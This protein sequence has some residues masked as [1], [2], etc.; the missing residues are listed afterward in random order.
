M[1][2]KRMMIQTSGN[3]QIPLDLYIPEVTDEID[4]HIQRPSV[5]ICPGG[6]YCF[7]SKRESEPVALAFAAAGFNAFVVWNRV[8]PHCFPLPQQDAA[9]AMAFVRAHAQEWH[10]DPNR[11]AILGFSAGGHLAGSI[12]TLW[13]KAELWQDIG[14]LPEQVRPNAMVLC[15]PV[16]TGGKYAHR[17]S[18]ESLSGTTDEREHEKYSVNG[19]VT[20][21]CPPT[22][23]WHTFD[24]DA[25][26]V[27]NSLLMA[28]ALADHGILTELHIYAHG[29]HGASLCNEQTA[30]VK[31]PTLVLPDNAGWVDAAQRF[32]LSTMGA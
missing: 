23:L 3:T 15:Y 2:G 21:Y 25:V 32:L 14:L 6:G 10:T 7:L 13:H 4:E 27:Q 16:I 29:G 19:W 1:I 5:V 17:G 11:I 20:E 12:G 26:P 31:N 8:A 24:D 22:F 18:F 28:E 30:G 9:A